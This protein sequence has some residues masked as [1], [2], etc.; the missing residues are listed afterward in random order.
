MMMTPDHR[1]GRYAFRWCILIELIE[2]STEYICRMI[3]YSMAE[4]FDAPQSGLL[5][6]GS[7]R[8]GF[9]SQVLERPY[10]TE[11]IDRNGFARCARHY[12]LYL[13]NMELYLCG[14][15]DEYLWK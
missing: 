4:M 5:T 2:L 3:S 13:E 10:F 14:P 11:R 7:Q 8:C 12:V 9:G 1:T 15:L 6:V